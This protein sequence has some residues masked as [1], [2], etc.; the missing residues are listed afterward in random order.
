MSPD[1]HSLTSIFDDLEPGDF[2]TA[3]PF[4][5]DAPTGLT[6]QAWVQNNLRMSRFAY[7]AAMGTPQQV[8]I[9]ASATVERWYS[10]LPE[11]SLGDFL[12]RVQAEARRL[13]ATRMFTF[14]LTMGMWSRPEPE[15]VRLQ[16]RTEA[17]EPGMSRTLYFYAITTEEPETAEAHR[18]I[19]GGLEINGSFTGEVTYAYPQQVTDLYEILPESRKR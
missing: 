10:P 6:F 5:Q 8:I 11:E 17:E 13:I 16:V 9:L 15:Q 19:H 12:A 3:E 2:A 4:H 18:R 14:R 1:D 7:A